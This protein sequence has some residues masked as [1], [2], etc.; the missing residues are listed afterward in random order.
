VFLPPV[1]SDAATTTDWTAVAAYAGAIA[2][3][4]AGL[5]V[6]ATGFGVIDQYRRGRRTEGNEAIWRLL[7]AWDDPL[8]RARR[9]VVASLLRQRPPTGNR[10]TLDILN[11]FDVLGSWLESGAV[12]EK[13]AWSPFSSYAL[14]YWFAAAWQI[15]AQ[16]TYDKTMLADYGRLVERF[17]LVEVRERGMSA[18]EVVADYTSYREILKFL[19][20]EMELWSFLPADIT[21]TWNP[22]APPPA[23]VAIDPAL[24]PAITGAEPPQV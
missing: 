1:L 19:D 14:S 11:L 9:A 10:M 6:I 17:I 5:A 15:Q 22:P 7:A 24:D 18:E 8:M 4:I 2:A 3:G 12:D 21:A 20:N 13:A 16:Q 23:P